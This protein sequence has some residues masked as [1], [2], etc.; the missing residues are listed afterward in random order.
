[1]VDERQEFWKR[2][3]TPDTVRVDRSGPLAVTELSGAQ[4]EHVALADLEPALRLGALHVVKSDAIAALD[5][6][7]APQH[8]SVNQ[9]AAGDEAAMAR[10]ARPRM[11]RD[12][13][14]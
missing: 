6:L 10:L 11:I 13:R 9:Y 12:G 14:S 8:G 3:G 7:H 1:F 4:Q 5:E 2:S